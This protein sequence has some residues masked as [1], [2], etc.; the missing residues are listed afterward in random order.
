MVMYI[1][2]MTCVLVVGGYFAWYGFNTSRKKDEYPLWYIP[3][4]IGIFFI[5]CSFYILIDIIE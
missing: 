5:F 2:L 4:S 1:L 3:M